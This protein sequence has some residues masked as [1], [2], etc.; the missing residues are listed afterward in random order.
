MHALKSSLWD[1]KKQKAHHHIVKK[2]NTNA[3]DRFQVG[4]DRKI[5]WVKESIAKITYL[6]FFCKLP[7]IFLLCTTGPTLDHL[8]N[9]RGLNITTSTHPEAIETKAAHFHPTTQAQI[10]SQPYIC[11]FAPSMK[12]SPDSHRTAYAIEI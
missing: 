7:H 3:Y 2:T 8:N 9:S 1:V 6:G 4:Y 10:P 11:F 12:P 5:R